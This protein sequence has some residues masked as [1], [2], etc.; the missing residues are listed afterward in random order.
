MIAGKALNVN[1]VIKRRTPIIYVHFTLQPKSEIKQQVPSEYN[2]LAYVVNGQGLF[3]SNRNSAT[4]GQ[5]V[6]FS[7]G[8]TIS[9]KNES[10]DSAMD[11]LL[12]AGVPLNEPVV[13]YGPFVM[14]EPHE[15]EQALEDYKSGRM[16]KINF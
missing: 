13:R 7:T 10:D 9:I 4:R 1:A 5:M 11:V 6:I 14:N 2:A 8:G 12:I 16:G 15:I 3:R